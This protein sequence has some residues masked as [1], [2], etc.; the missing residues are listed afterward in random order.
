VPS[1]GWL[2]LGA[3]VF[4]LAAAHVDPGPLGGHHAGHR[5]AGLG[6]DRGDRLGP[7]PVVTGQV[8]RAGGLAARGHQQPEAPLRRPGAGRPASGGVVGRELGDDLP[9]Y[10]QPFQL[11]LGVGELLTR[12]LRLAG[13]L[14][15][16]AGDP[17]R[18]LHPAPQGLL[19]LYP[20]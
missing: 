6:R 18:Q 4:G 1:A 13:Q 17:F 10:H 7:R 19:L 8:A 12:Q 2:E 20:P 14:G 9:G 11:A 5:P 15:Y 3:D 16:P